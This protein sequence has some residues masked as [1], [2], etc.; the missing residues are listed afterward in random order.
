MSQ[1]KEKLP[2]SEFY[3]V[4]DYIT[5]SKSQKWWSA[6]VLTEAYGKRKVSL[7]LWTNK[8][9]KWTRKHKYVISSKNDWTTV[10]NAVETLLEK[11]SPS[12]PQE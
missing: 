6:A 1:E 3:R 7:Y 9:G 4:I 2:L 10:K 12:K 11:L 8:N 5:I